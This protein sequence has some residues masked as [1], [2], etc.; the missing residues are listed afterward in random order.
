M[1]KR[2]L[3]LFFLVCW[4]FTACSSGR[5][6]EWVKIRPFATEKAV[7]INSEVKQIN[8]TLSLVEKEGEKS[9][10]QLDSSKLNT[11][12][13]IEKTKS[14][15]VQNNGLEN[16]RLSIK[17]SLDADYQLQDSFVQSLNESVTL[18]LQIDSTVKGNIFRKFSEF[19]TS[20]D[21]VAQKIAIVAGIIT[22]ILI[23]ILVSVY[24]KK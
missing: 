17:Q 23:A 24:F 6:Y 22:A 13:F 16:A 1:E 9:N 15:P 2:V 11:N 4:F 5:H 14:S 19:W 10:K 12:S 7:S 20:D 8:I 3:F 18:P 21:H